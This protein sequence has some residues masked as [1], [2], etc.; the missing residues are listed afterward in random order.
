MLLIETLIFST[1]IYYFQSNFFYK[2][3]LIF[4]FHILEFYFN[5]YIFLFVYFSN[6]WQLIFFDQQLYDDLL[7]EILR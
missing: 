3:V 6:K 5:Q 4:F 2:Y 7:S 1:F